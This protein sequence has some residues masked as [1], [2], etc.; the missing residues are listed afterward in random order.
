MSRF[1]IRE[2]AS[3]AVVLLTLGLAG[4]LDLFAPECDNC[5]NNAHWEYTCVGWI[6]PVCDTYCV[7]SRDGGVRMLDKCC[8]GGKAQSGAVPASVS[9]RPLKTRAATM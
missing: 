1:R 5:P 4:C 9:W 3:V 2:W 8:C 6:A 7:E